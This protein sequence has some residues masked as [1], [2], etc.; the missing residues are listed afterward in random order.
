VLVSRLGERIIPLQRAQARGSAR[1]VGGGE[2]GL[3]GDAGLSNE[4][5]RETGRE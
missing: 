3:R 1:L 5:R 4:P 2:K